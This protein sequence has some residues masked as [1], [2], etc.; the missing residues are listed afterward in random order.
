MNS[1]NPIEIVTTTIENLTC[2]DNFIGKIFYKNCKIIISNFQC[3]H[4]VHCTTI[5]TRCYSLFAMIPTAL[6]ELFFKMYLP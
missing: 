5:A 1:I 4:S 6:I 3:T 2:F